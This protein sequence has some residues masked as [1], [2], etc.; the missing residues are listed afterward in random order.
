MFLIIIFNII[1]IYFLISLLEWY[2]HKNLMHKGN[3]NIFTSLIN[4]IY[5]FIYKVHHSTTHLK[6]HNITQND[7]KVENDEALF[8]DKFHK[9]LLPFPVIIIIYLLNKYLLNY[10]FL[11]NNLILYFILLF[12]ISW[13]YEILWNKIHSKIHKWKNH[14]N[15]NGIFENNFYYKFLEKYHMIHHYNKGNNKC[16]Y[17]IVLPGIDY[18]MGTYKNCVDNTEFCK[19]HK[20]DSSK[21]FDLCNKQ[22][23]NINLPYNIKYC[24]K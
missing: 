13:F 23:N 4:K 15:K 14:Y 11:F 9:F 18:I 8:F 22:E 17:N 5:F 21:N 24:S 6:H 10:T 3:K 19:K 1:I 16:N 20:F 7:G 12:F 2:I